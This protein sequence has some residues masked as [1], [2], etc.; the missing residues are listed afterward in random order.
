MQKQIELHGGIVREPSGCLKDSR[1]E[2]SMRRRGRV[3]CPRPYTR[4]PCRRA[5]AVQ[6][7]GSVRSTCQSWLV[8][9]VTRK[10]VG[11]AQPH[12]DVC[13]FL[14]IAYVMRA[15]LFGKWVG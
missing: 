14:G 13:N 11:H 1:R 9:D 12:T 8:A 7:F 4:G 6:E 10:Q 2:T 3:L 15:L 5:Q